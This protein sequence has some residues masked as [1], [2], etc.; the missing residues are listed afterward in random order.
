MDIDSRIQARKNLEEEP[1][2]VAGDLRAVR[3]VV[4]ADIA[5][6][7]FFEERERSALQHESSMRP[8]LGELGEE[9]GV[10]VWFDES[11]VR[12]SLVPLQGTPHEE[13]GPTASDFHDPARGEG[14]QQAVLHQRVGVIP[15][16]VIPT[17]SAGTRRQL[18]GNISEF[19]DI[20][21]DNT[22]CR[23]LAVQI[24]VDLCWDLRFVPQ[25]AVVGEERAVVE[26]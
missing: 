15:E 10:R 20:S 19:I 25:I 17:I 26:R 8:V 24:P 14:A 2:H 6:L 22:G 21:R 11:D 16:T 7:E 3:A 4:K 1:I 23:D 5:C 12:V 18:F 13:A 9:V